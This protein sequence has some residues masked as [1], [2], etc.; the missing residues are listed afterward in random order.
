VADSDLGLDDALVALLRQAR[1]VV[2]L[3][4]AGI[5]AESGVPT[6]R[7]AQQ[8]LW[9]KYDP[10]ELATPEGFAR[11]PARVWEWYTMRRA[12]MANVEPNAGHRA[13]ARWGQLRPELLVVTQNVDGLHQRAGSAR[14]IELHGNIMRTKCSAENLVVEHWEAEPGEVPRCGQCAAYLR[15]DVVWFGEM[16]PMNALASAERA[17]AEADLVLSVGTSS[18]VQPAASLPYSALEAGV[19]VVEVNPEETPLTADAT[20]SLR[21]GAGRVLPALVACLRG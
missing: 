1:R 19:A 15:P 11:N 10:A 16:L 18:L 2:A 4:G 3:T 14:V 7:D 5:S 6:F 8:G 20:F 12:L 17:V 9:A 13:L 21:G